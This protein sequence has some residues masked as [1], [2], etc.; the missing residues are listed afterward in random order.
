M[1]KY[2]TYKLKS[3][4]LEREVDVYIYLPKNYNSTDTKYPVLYMFDGHNLFD[5]ALSYVGVSWGIP[6]AYETRDDLPELIIVGVT[7]SFEGYNRII[8]YSPLVNDNI[9]EI[10]P[11]FKGKLVGK[12][13]N[14]LEMITKEL[15]PYIDKTYRTLK[16][17]KNTGLAG[18]S[19]GG[20][21]T[22][23]ASTSYTNYFSRFGC[24]SSAFMFAG[25]PIFKQVDDADFSNVQKLYMDVGTNEISRPNAREKHY[26]NT[27]NEIYKLVSDKLP[28]EKLRYVL[29]E[30]GEHSES[31]W[32]RRFPEALKFMFE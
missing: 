10:L 4:E 9:Q 23:Y 1:Q 12:G 24:F 13:V 19:M 17:A 5:N 28:K 20:L 7:P 31:D 22:T 26:I 16:D 25:K 6:E 14:T 3:K 32:S 15:K 2:L 27:N 18:S 8:E 29:E 11:D 21:L 30:G